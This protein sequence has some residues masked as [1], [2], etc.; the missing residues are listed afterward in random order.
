[1]ETKIF[2]MTERIKSVRKFCKINNM[3]RTNFRRRVD[4]LPEGI[5]NIKINNI[6]LTVYKAIDN[7]T[8]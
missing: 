6:E 5:H 1:M 4:K 7:D 3:S 8:I 2:F